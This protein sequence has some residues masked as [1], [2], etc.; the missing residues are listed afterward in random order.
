MPKTLT[1][2]G[3]LKIASA[4]ISKRIMKIVV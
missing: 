2:R 3:N 1:K 4:V